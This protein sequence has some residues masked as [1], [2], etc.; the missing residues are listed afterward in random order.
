MP[1]R[2]KDAA[3]AVP[4]RLLLVADDAS[5]AMRSV[6]A[7]ATRLAKQFGAAVHVV[8]VGSR[9]RDAAAAQDDVMFGRATAD[10]EAAAA[11]VQRR[12]R[13]LGVAAQVHVE[14]GP[15]MEA[16]VAAERRLAPD[17]FLF[18]HTERA[19][20]EFPGYGTVLDQ[21]KNQV[22]SSVLVVHGQAFDGVA[23]GVD[24]SEPS[25][26][27]AAT[28]AQWA[29]ALHVPLTLLLGPEAGRLPKELQGHRTVPVEGPPA[30]F[31]L[32]WSRRHPRGLLVLGARGLGNPH[33]LRMGSVSD[34]VAWGASS[35]V[36]VVRPP[37]AHA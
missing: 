15:V 8:I 12:F 2:R 37:R 5:F 19:H 16:L 18:G 35:S 17:V 28:A 36:L 14:R 24:G 13:D 9:E 32:E 23:A 29:A 33:L 6:E 34:R 21:V 31:L 25:L 20:L 27:A 7:V 1:F 3:K 30:E 26:A 11:E 22:A 4:V 10:V